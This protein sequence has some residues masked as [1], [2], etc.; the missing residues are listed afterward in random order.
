METNS[1]CH[2]IR[3]GVHMAILAIH[4]RQRISKLLIAIYYVS[5]GRIYRLWNG[6]AKR[7]WG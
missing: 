4:S 7:E 6:F 2:A 1:I 3:Y 5:I